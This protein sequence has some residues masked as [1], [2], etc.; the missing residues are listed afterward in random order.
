MDTI[1]NCLPCL[2][3]R[4]N[5]EESSQEEIDISSRPRTENTQRRSGSI[6]GSNNL[7]SEIPLNAPEQQTVGQHSNVTEVAGRENAPKTQADIENEV[8]TGANTPQQKLALVKTELTEELEKESYKYG[9][10]K[11][12][13][14][15]A[16]KAVKIAEEHGFKASLERETSAMLVEKGT[17]RGDARQSNTEEKKMWFF[18]SHFWCKIEGIQYDPLFDT[19][20]RPNMDLQDGIEEYRDYRIYKFKSGNAMVEGQKDTQITAN[21]VF[22]S[23]KDAQEFVLKTTPDYKSDSD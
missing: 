14:Y 12:C 10:G 17:I 1:K 4:R 3:T 6:R 15:L 11:D 7:L 13:G 9:S 2:R 18:G 8:S 19:E 5:T 21:T 20:G 16:D 23:Y 22:Q